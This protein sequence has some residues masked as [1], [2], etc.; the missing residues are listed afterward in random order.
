MGDNKW[1][2][3]RRQSKKNKQA[4]TASWKN[5]LEEEDEKNGFKANKKNNK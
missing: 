3:D 5:A 4:M 2:H 1:S